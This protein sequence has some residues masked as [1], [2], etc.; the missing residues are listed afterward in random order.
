M[1]RAFDQA[2]QNRPSLF[3]NLK[4]KI[5]LS[6]VEVRLVPVKE[7]RRAIV[8]GHYS[9]VMPDATQEAFAAYWNEVVI[10]AV[11]YGPGG[12]SKT[13]GA[14]VQGFDSSNARELIRLWVHPDAPKNTAS[15]VVSKTLKMLPDSVGLVV[16]FADSGQGHFGYV[17]Q[18][19]NFFY[20]GMSNE[21]VRY[22][23][24]SGV[25]VTA[26]LANVYKTRNPDKFGDMSLGDIRNQ[27]GWKPVKSHAKHR[28]C[29]GVGKQKRTVTKALLGKSMPYPKPVTIEA[30]QELSTLDPQTDNH[31]IGSLKLT[32]ED[33]Q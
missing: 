15:F 19:L 32:A 11:A 6:E 5:A 22:V 28:Y 7:I 25:E 30:G 3:D 27:L 13:F 9:G 8:T 31:S 29:I 24:S 23:D 4:L 14:V 1:T 17:Y 10:A 2:V 33:R 20:C 21:G 18:S 26:R 12:N 16:S